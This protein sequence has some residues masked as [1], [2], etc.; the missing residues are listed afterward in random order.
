MKTALIIYEG[1]ADQPI[2]VLKDR[3]PMQTARCP[4]ASE[5]AVKGQGGLIR[6]S[7][8]EQSNRAEMRLAQYLGQSRKEA[9]TQWR[10]PLEALGANVLCEPADWVWRADLV[11]MDESRLLEAGVARLSMEET[12]D[13]A[14]AV[15]E[16][17]DKETLILTAVQPGVVIVRVRDHG[18]EGM[19]SISPFTA[20]GGELGDV[21][22]HKRNNSFAREF[23]EKSQTA[24]GNHAVNDVRLDLGENPANA[25]WPWGGGPAVTA[26][27]AGR[28]PFSGVVATQSLLA[29]GLART[30][31]LNTVDLLNPWKESDHKRTPFR[32]TEMVEALREHD[33]VTVYVEAPG[34]GGRYGDAPDKVWAMELLD[35]VILAP[36]ITLLEAWRPWR[37]ALCVDSAVLCR[38]GCAVPGALPF[39]VSG[40]GVNPDG[41]D[42]WDEKVCGAGVRGVIRADELIKILREE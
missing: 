16:E 18:P 14:N 24:L 4:L 30:M 40:Q 42:H 37:I 27:E 20:E 25:L 3:T 9:R 6:P 10:G 36:I 15:Q 26:A 22:L 13:L 41:V 23:I 35:H 8:A 19:D 38:Y 31:G 39:I 17:W 1:M 7:R 12:V 5:L 28:Q 21:L 2:D 33:H 29:R 34:A 11:T 32:I